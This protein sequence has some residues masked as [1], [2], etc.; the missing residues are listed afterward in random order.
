[1]ALGFRDRLLLGSAVKVVTFV[2]IAVIGLAVLTG[3]HASEQVLQ[4]IDESRASFGIQMELHL[5]AWRRETR[6]FARSPVLLAMAAIPGVDAATFDDQ[7]HGM[8][9]PLVAVVD[10]KGKVLAGRGGFVVGADV[11]TMPGFEAALQSDVEDHVWLLPEGP[12]LVAVAPLAQGGELL[13]AL[14]RGERIDHAL[15]NRLG[16]IGASDVMLVHDGQVLGRRWRKQ[17]KGV[18]DLRALQ[19]LLI[20]DLP[21]EGLPLSLDVDGE[22]RRG[23]ALRL[24]DDGGIAFLSHDVSHIEALRDDARLWLLGSGALLAL[25]GLVFALHMAS[26]LARPLQALTSAS[27]RMGRG[28]L[29]VRVDDRGMDR[30]L[31]AL[32]R[33]FNAMA[34]TMQTLVRDVTDKAARAEAANRAKDGFL[35]SVSHELRT[36]LTGIQ[37]TAELLQQFGDGATPEERAEFLGTILREAERLGRRI[38][39]ALEFANLAGGKARWTI[40]RVDLRRICEEACRRLH[41]LQGLKPVEFRILGDDGAVLAGDREHLTQAVHHLVHNAWQW[42]QAEGEVEIVVRRVQNGFVIDVADRGPG[43]RQ[44]DRERVF[45][46]FTQ[47]GDVLVDKPAGIGIGLKIA[48]EVAAVHGGAIEYS[49]RAGGGACFHL[50]VRTVERP[51]DTMAL[52]EPCAD[53]AASPPTD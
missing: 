51:I 14:V 42:S 33:S 18:V 4:A 32:A 10:P 6:E 27:D 2:T 40:G 44:E 39:D 30:E 15:A 3:R 45:E 35:T 53:A 16:A 12:A 36:P 7:L 47:G 8:A 29:G 28:D 25:T 22:L 31:G 50:L 21:P 34:A 23:L 26:R 48:A 24:H 37:S 19:D 13:G 49:D 5:R 11:R 52:P 38:G 41:G 20:A 43:L 46:L 17:P 1:M 9:A